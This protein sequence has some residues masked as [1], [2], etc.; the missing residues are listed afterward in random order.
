MTTTLEAVLSAVYLGVGTALFAAAL[1]LVVLQHRGLYPCPPRN[2][3]NYPLLPIHHVLPQ[4][5]P[6]VPFYPPVPIP[7]GGAAPIHNYPRFVH[8]ADEE[9]V[10]GEVEDGVQEGSNGS[11]ARTGHL[12]GHRPLAN[13]DTSAGHTPHPAR[14]APTADAADLARYLVRLGLGTDG[15]QGTPVSEQPASDGPGDSPADSTFRLDV[16]W[17]NVNL[18]YT[19]FFPRRG[20]PYRRPTPDP[21][22]PVIHWDEPVQITDQ[23]TRDARERERL[24]SEAFR[25]VDEEAGRIS[26][27]VYYSGSNTSTE[28]L[29][30]AEYANGNARGSPDTPTEPHT[31]ENPN[32]PPV[33]NPDDHV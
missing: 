6:P 7:N 11:P 21:D 25:R 15:Q 8:G 28:V 32:S 3:Q 20:N 19:A 33:Y 26:P 5:P 18:P 2:Q 29:P 27:T 12:A 17:D 16:L 23:A 1:V 24:R 31:P 13:A 22:Y 10:L 30:T 9:N 4:Q 14:P